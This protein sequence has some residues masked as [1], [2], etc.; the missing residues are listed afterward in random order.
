[1]AEGG[2]PVIAPSPV[3]FNETDPLPLALDAAG[4]D[5][6]VRAFEAAAHRALGAGFKVIEIHSAHGY[7]LHE[8][9][10]PLANRRQDEF[11]GSLENRMRLLLRVADRLRRLMPAE[12]PLFVRISASDWADGGWDI[13][14][15]VALAKRL[16]DLGVDLID[17]SSGGMVPRANIPVAKGYQVPFAKRIRNEAKIKTAAVGLITE[18]AHANE[19]ITEGDAD[20]VLLA[21]EFLREPYWALKAQRELGAEPT[22]PIQYGYAVKR[23]AK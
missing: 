16:A 13:E 1:L 4:I 5:D 23:R 6:V 20:F 17:V 8:F 2:W 3:P 15:S 14:H 19:I 7:L 18:P 22:W 12:L 11:G 10:S 9:L 21:R